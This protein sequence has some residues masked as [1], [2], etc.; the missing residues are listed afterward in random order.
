MWFGKLD[1]HRDKGL[2]ILRVGIGLM[3]MRHG[4]PKLAA[5]P[6]MWAGVGQALSAL[7]IDFGHTAMGLVAALSEFGGGLLLALGLLTR[8]ACFFLFCTM[9]VA[10]TMH[11]SRGD[12]FQVY[13]HAL[14]AAILFASL[15]L[16]GPGRYS[17]DRLWLKRSMQTRDAG[18]AALYSEP[19]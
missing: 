12:G 18:Q 17:L 7:G 9:A 5:G 11:V 16:I 14:E 19:G 10:T 1:G 8:P 15:I 2:L 13:S 6:E 4:Y 3:F